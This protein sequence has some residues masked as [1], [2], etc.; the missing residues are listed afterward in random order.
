LA[1]LI[2]T[3]AIVWIAT[4]PEKLSAAARE[5]LERET[6]FVSAVTA[7]EFADLNRRERFDADLPLS[8]LLE[9]LGATALDYPAGAWSIA[10]ALP[11]L[12]RD[13]V[14]RMLIAHAI[15]AD[16]TLVTADSTIHR[17]PLRWLW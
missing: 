17:Y 15:H 11:D 3:Q 2:D 6:L 10:T 14:D 5:A 16:L 7:F 12:H 1:L 4:A 8:P 13:P 9:R